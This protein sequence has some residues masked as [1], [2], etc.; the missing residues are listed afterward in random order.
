MWV[1]DCTP[2]YYACKLLI[3]P[4]ICYLSLPTVCNIEQTMV[5]LNCMTLESLVAGIF[6]GSS[7]L[8]EIRIV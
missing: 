3:N 7:Y 6:P 2:S 1:I 4:F 5:G 8:W